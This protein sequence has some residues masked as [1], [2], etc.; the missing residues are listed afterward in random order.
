[1]ND[2]NAVDWEE[3]S[4]RTIKVR[5]N[6]K[7]ISLVGSLYANLKRAFLKSYTMALKTYFDLLLYFWKYRP[8]NRA[9]LKKLPSYLGD[10]DLV[11]KMALINDEMTSL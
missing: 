3:A 10:Y 9:I 11:Y 7:C 4:K 1:M 8:L 2:R 6:K 5:S